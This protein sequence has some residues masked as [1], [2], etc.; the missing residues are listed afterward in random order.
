MEVNGEHRQSVP[1]GY[2]KPEKSPRRP[3]YHQ[4]PPDY[5]FESNSGGGGFIADVPE[6]LVTSD[7]VGKAVYPIGRKPMAVNFSQLQVNLR[8]VWDIIPRA[9]QKSAVEIEL[10]SLTGDDE[11]Q[12]NDAELNFL[13]WLDMEIKKID[14]FYRE[15]ENVAGQRY[16]HISEQLEALRQ[17]E[18]NHL[19]NESKSYRDISTPEPRGHEGR[20]NFR[21]TC[22][23]WINGIRASFD[24]LSSAMPDADHERRAKHPELMAR[25]ITTN[26]GYV[27]YRVARRRLK[28]AILEFYRGMELLKEYRLL[29]RTGLEKILKKFDKTSGRK[30]SGKYAEKLKSMHL[31]KSDELETLINDTEV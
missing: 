7:S 22:Q 18:D 10:V 11:A 25:P 9:R 23:S 20:F 16:K 5:L 29:N 17:L 19:M 13:Y 24:N 27:E 30:I 4:K 31:E 28:H 21:S 14:H 1:P 15:K 2:Y 8:Q 3:S 26:T 12:F 6:K